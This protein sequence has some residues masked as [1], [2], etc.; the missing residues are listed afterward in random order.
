MDICGSI[1]AMRC[2]HEM[3]GQVSMDG[4]YLLSAPFFGSSFPVPEATLTSQTR[5]SH[6]WGVWC[7]RTPLLAEED[8][9]SKPSGGREGDVPGSWS[10][11]DSVAR[12]LRPFSCL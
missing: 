2:Q 4:S 6:Q 7:S 5:S 9:S 8:T 1:G 10:A 3:L 11:W 12:E